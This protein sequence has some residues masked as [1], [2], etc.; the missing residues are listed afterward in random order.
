M[1]ELGEYSRSS[2]A[3]SKP[4]NR[5]SANSRD[6]DD[7]GTDGTD[8]ID[9]FHAVDQVKAVEAV[10]DEEVEGVEGVEGLSVPM[11]S[12]SQVTS[13]RLV[14]AGWSQLRSATIRHSAAA[15]TTASVCEL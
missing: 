12:S 9:G 1:T 3:S 2:H 15:A 8:R 10:D 5:A 7:R 11:S 13:R 4:P 14:N 6:Q